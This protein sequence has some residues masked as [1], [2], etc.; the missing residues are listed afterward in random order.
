MIKNEKKNRF[1]N[2]E[3]K[4]PTKLTF[5]LLFIITLAIL[6]AGFYITLARLHDIK[7]VIDGD[8]TYYGS[9]IYEDDYESINRGSGLREFTYKVREGFNVRVTIFRTLD[10]PGFAPL[11]L[12]IYDN[13]NLVTNITGSVD[14]RQIRLDHTVGE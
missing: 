5:L 11:T 2:K 12:E 13:D 6:V 8:G 10:D 9:V 7:V 4:K 1:W 3:A 14:Q